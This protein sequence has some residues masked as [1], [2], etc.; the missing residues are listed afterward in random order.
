MVLPGHFYFTQLLLPLMISTARASPDGIARV[1]TVS[2]MGHLV[3]AGLNFSTFKDSPARKKMNTVELYFQSKFVRVL[4]ARSQHID[5]SIIDNRV[6][7]LSP[8]NLIDDIEIKE[9]SPFL[10]ILVVCITSLLFDI[11]IQSEGSIKTDL[12]TNVRGPLNFI[13]VRPS[14]F[15]FLR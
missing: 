12:F 9:L 15:L 1:I 5:W 10:S 3:G 4:I 6:T 2:S 7:L 11:L 13:L 8:Q 14:A